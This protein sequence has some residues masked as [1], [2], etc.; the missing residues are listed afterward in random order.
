MER[1]LPFASTS[2]YLDVLLSGEHL[3]CLNRSIRFAYLPSFAMQTA[4]P[5]SDYYDG[6]VTIGLS[7]LRPSRV[8]CELNVSRPT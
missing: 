6:S 7:P 4:F 1:E 3:A 8:P 5:F 2:D